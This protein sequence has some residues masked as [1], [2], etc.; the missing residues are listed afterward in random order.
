MNSK[1]KIINLEY[2]RP[3]V[4]EACL[5][6][7]NEIVTAKRMG[8]K[9]CKVIHGY[10][11]SGVGGNLKSGVSSWLKKY[12]RKYQLKVVIPGE[13]WSVSEEKTS[14]VLSRYDY[15]RKDSDM[16]RRNPGITIVVF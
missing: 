12:K 6:L 9:A 3:I 4:S 7:G 16:G 15:L 8:Y 2:N 10:G 5:K 14:K 13:E 1:I 11:S